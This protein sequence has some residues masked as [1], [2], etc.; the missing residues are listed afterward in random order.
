MS[1]SRWRAGIVAFRTKWPV[2]SQ[3]FRQVSVS[4]G[5]SSRIGP[6]PASG[7]SAIRGASRWSNGATRPTP[8]SCAAATAAPT[9]SVPKTR[10]T[11]AAMP[12]NRIGH[13][14][15][16]AGPAPDRRPACARATR[17]AVGTRSLPASDELAFYRLAGR[18]RASRLPG[19]PA[20]K[21]AK[22]LDRCKCPQ[23][24]ENCRVELFR[25]PTVQD[26]S[27]W[28][29]RRTGGV[30]TGSPSPPAPAR[31]SR[32]RTLRGCPATPGSRRPRARTTRRCPRSAAA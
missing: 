6:S 21:F 10:T 17:R 2:Y 19:V 29:R 12:V 18:R 32:S 8:A 26:T 30:E 16:D 7:G 25:E 15:G 20:V 23:T 9:T 27:R 13:L 4:S 28:R 1:S 24:L 5:Q 22:A 3:Y 14:P 11:P 31:R